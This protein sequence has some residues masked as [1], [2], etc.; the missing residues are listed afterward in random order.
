DELVELLLHLLQRLALRVDDHGHPGDA[1]LLRRAHGQGMDVESTA[2]EQPR[3]PRQDARLILHQHR[4]RVDAHA[5]G[6]S[7]G[8]ST[9][10]TP[11]GP[12]MMSSFDAP[13][14]TMGKTISPGSTRKSMTTLRSPT[15]SALSSTASTS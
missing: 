15:D 6:A 1:R 3:H 11:S 9:G 5:I 8:S 10:R 14:G 7:A 2:G 13:A 12:R 4:D